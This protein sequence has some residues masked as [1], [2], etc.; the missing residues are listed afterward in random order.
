MV[1]EPPQTQVEQ[2]SCYCR[3]Q[4]GWVPDGTISGPT[5][6]YPYYGWYGFP[7]LPFRCAEP[8]PRHYHYV[9]RPLRPRSHASRPQPCR[10]YRHPAPWADLG[11]APTSRQISSFWT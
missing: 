7:Y 2:V 4:Y 9:L 10:R 5:G 11:G 8:R 1:V 3:C 6:G